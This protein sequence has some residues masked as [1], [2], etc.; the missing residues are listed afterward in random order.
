[1]GTAYTALV[2]FAI[3]WLA[4]LFGS[5]VPHNMWSVVH[6]YPFALCLSL[7]AKLHSG[8][9]IHPGAAFQCTAVPHAQVIRAGGYHT[10][11]HW[12]KA[13]QTHV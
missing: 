3:G 1:M 5:I 7:I 12:G 2:M 8:V 10:W 9:T 4:G 11:M 6:E 13:R